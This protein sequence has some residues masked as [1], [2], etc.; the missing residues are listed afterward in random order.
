MRGGDGASLRLSKGTRLRSRDVASYPE[1]LELEAVWKHLSPEGAMGFGWIDFSTSTYYYLY[2]D[3]GK[4]RLGLQRG[5]SKGSV[6]LME[7]PLSRSDRSRKYGIRASVERGTRVKLEVLVDGAMVGEPVTDTL[8]K[9][10]GSTYQIYAGSGAE[11]TV[12]LEEISTIPAG[13]RKAGG[14]WFW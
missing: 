14:N 1:V 12:E 6:L 13:V 8:E 10:L 2:F 11:A 7:T 4:E 5:D 9:G 3:A